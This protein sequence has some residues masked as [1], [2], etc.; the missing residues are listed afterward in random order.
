M[1]LSVARMFTG[2]F[3][4]TPMARCCEQLHESELVI[5]AS[6]PTCLERPTFQ[7][8]EFQESS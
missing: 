3:R 2:S 1:G 4:C 5:V 8:L 7:T 6:A